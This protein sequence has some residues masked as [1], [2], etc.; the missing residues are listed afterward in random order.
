MPPRTR[1]GSSQLG[2][3]IRARRI[4]LGLS[5][6]EASTKAGVGTKSWSRYEAGAAIREDKVRGVC[7]AL[8]W[9]RLPEAGVE[10]D[11]DSDEGWLLSVDEGHEA[12]SPV[13]EAQ[14]GRACAVA[15]AVGSDML[16][17]HVT[18]DLNAL[19]Q[20]PRGTHVGELGASWL[21]GSLPEQFVPRYDYEFVYALQAA[22]RV[23]RERFSGG[24]LVVETVMEQLALYLILSETDV[25]ADMSERFLSDHDDWR[26]WLGDILGDTDVEFY[27][28]T[29]GLA[30]TPRMSYHFD[31][32][33]KNQ[34]NAAG[35]LMT[36]A[37]RA[38][39]TIGT[40]FADPNGTKT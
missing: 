28:F 19:A 8:R 34:F 18:A 29:S 20:E 36:S 40:L 32:W 26:E 37:E 6:E 14:F 9:T 11:G 22:C 2:V 7:K 4:A 15:F 30:L 10:P 21:D 23:L 27:L 3:A 33:N 5:I 12:W 38:A 24:A 39:E 31:H 16:I 17:D 35:Q 25:L 13:L 1:P